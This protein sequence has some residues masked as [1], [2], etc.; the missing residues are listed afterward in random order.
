MS[1]LIINFIDFQTAFD[2]IHRPTL[3]K[4]HAIY[5]FQTKFINFIKAFYSESKCCAQTEFGKTEWFSVETGVKQ[6]CFLS[7]MLFSIAVGW[8]KR[9]CINSKKL[10]IRWVDNK[11]LADLDFADDL[12]LLSSTHPDAQ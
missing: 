6:R 12:G 11:L 1:P 4:I 9:K 3:C 2:S 8:I 5:S 7:P 10:G